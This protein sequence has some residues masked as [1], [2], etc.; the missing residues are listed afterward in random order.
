M[1]DERIL[2]INLKKRIV[3]GP[4]WRRNSYGMRLI[5]ELIKKHAKVE[6]VKIDKSLNEKM[7][8]KS[9]QKPPTILRLK[10]VKVDDK[11]VKAELLEK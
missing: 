3:R 4:K 7:W 9:V 6:K 5:R 10:I 1:A 2:T 11:T 8:S